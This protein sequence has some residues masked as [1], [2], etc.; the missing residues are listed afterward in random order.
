MTGLR[1]H[2]RP[3][4][5]GI[6]DYVPS[7]KDAV[8]PGLGKDW[9]DAR[10]RGLSVPQWRAAQFARLDI[11]PSLQ[12]LKDGLVLDLGANVGDWTAALL[13]V[14]PSVTVIAV[15]PADTPREYLEQRFAADPRVTV[16]ARAVADTVGEREFHVTSHSHNGSLRE[17][18]PGM[19]D[20]YGYGWNVTDVVTVQTTTVDELSDGRDVGLLKIDVQGAERDVFEGATATLQRT[21]A[22]LLEVTFISHYDGDATFPWLHDYMTGHGY[23]LSGLSQPFMSQQ[24]TVTWC[25]A[26]YTRSD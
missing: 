22:I 18:Q 2:L 24:R 12:P 23:V 8:T 9:R 4:K 14:E 20:Y 25:D 1:D 3:I 7:I 17:P 15:E 16:D 13:R 21:A 5:H 10:K 26:C 11:L 6:R 19:N